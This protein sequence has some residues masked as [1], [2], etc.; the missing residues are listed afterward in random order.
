M[1]SSFG[2]DIRLLGSIHSPDLVSN[3]MNKTPYIIEDRNILKEAVRIHHNR[4]SSII[5]IIYQFYKSQQQQQ[6][7]LTYPR[8]YLINGDHNHMLSAIQGV[9]DGLSSYSNNNQQSS[10]IIRPI[11]IYIDLHADSRPIEDGPHSGT[12]CSE[13]HANGWIEQVNTN[14]K[15][16]FSPFNFNQN[17]FLFLF[18][19]YC[20]GLNPL[21]NSQLTLENLENSGTIYQRYTWTEIK[22]KNIT[23]NQIGNEIIHDI[24]TKFSLNHPIILSICGD[25]VL[26]LPSSAGTNTIGY[27]SDSIYE[28]ISLLIQQLNVT[29]FT[30]AELKT[31]LNPSQASN[32]GEF[33]TQCLFLYHHHNNNHKNNSQCKE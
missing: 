12:W 4:L 25:S 30:V 6:Q 13:A 1:N 28:V 21:A 3:C 16:D 18:K 2:N 27:S 31:S 15:I 29:C 5:S 26:H 33:L 8:V 10:Q 14:K 22:S 24:Q 11:V 23:F 9:T 7:Q 20:I 19:A 32:I 17:S